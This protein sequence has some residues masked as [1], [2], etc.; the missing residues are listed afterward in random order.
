MMLK[1][2][3]VAAG[4]TSILAQSSSSH[5]GS[6]SRSGMKIAPKYYVCN[7]LTGFCEM[8]PLTSPGS[9]HAGTSQQ[10]CLLTCKGTVWP[11]PSEIQQ[12][13]TG[14]TSD[15]C[16]ILFSKEA[17]YGSEPF[18]SIA[19]ENFVESL[20]LIKQSDG[21]EGVLTIVMNKTV[22]FTLC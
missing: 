22:S 2:I 17:M 6:D 19:I 20:S 8:E 21:C 14:S 12:M 18:E 10:K 13:V 11:A 5:S 4:A 1:P 9:P 3:L 15:F 7:E 16:N